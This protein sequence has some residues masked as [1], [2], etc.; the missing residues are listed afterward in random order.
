M[1]KNTEMRHVIAALALAA[2]ILSPIQVKGQDKDT[3]DKTW[4]SLVGSEKTIVEGWPRFI[5]QHQ[6]LEVSK[7]SNP[8]SVTRCL[9]TTPPCIVRIR[10]D[11]F[12][13]EWKGRIDD[14]TLRPGVLMHHYP[15]VLFDW[16]YRATG[17]YVFYLSKQKVF[18]LWGDC[19]MDHRD[20]VWGP[21][22]GD[23]RVILKKLADDAGF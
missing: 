14:S 3:S 1:Y 21:F 7:V 15:Q 22:A 19:V 10:V 13:S 23:P 12:F 17:T 16:H 11:D 6:K 4:P 9:T 2:F 18:Y 5:I 20:E 8:L